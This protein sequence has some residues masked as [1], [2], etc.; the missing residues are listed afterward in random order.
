MAYRADAPAGERQR[1]ADP[2]PQLID[3]A[4]VS[5]GRVSSNSSQVNAGV[6]VP[7]LAAGVGDSAMQTVAQNLA[8][9]AVAGGTQGS[10]GAVI[11]VG[12]GTSGHQQPAYSQRSVTRASTYGGSFSTAGAGSMPHLYTSASSG[13]TMQTNVMASSS[14]PLVAK[15]TGKNVT[16]QS[17]L[18]PVGA[19]SLPK[20]QGSQYMYQAPTLSASAHPFMPGPAAAEPAASSMPVVQESPGQVLTT[21]SVVKPPP[22]P[23]EQKYFPAANTAPAADSVASQPVMVNPGLWSW[24]NLKLLE[25]PKFSGKK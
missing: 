14:F 7:P 12:S 20:P 2:E 9:G 13:V 25:L 15:H 23:P 8:P 5:S 17:S 3:V 24:N 19:T 11:G 1:G 21:F 4:S 22:E 6:H 18:A 10:S 16:V